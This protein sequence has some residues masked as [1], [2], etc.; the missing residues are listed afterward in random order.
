[1]STPSDYSIPPLQVRRGTYSQVSAYQAALGEIIYATDRK[2]VFIGDG[3][4][5]GGIPITG[6]GGSLDFG[7]ILSPGGFSLDL[8]LI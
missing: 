4:T 7:S 5:A 8:G 1:M 6:T 2:S 3:T